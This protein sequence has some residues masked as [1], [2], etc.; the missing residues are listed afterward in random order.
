MAF[1][2]KAKIQDLDGN[3]FLDL[4][5]TITFPT[6]ESKYYKT[7]WRSDYNLSS[8]S[9]IVYGNRNLYWLILS[10]NGITNP[11]GFVPGQEFKI[12]LP[13]FLREVVYG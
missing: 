13:E 6:E 11:F 10:A 4:P 3:V 7:I 8:L 2:Y 9:N 1:Q 5:Q 12:L